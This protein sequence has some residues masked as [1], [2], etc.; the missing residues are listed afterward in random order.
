[1]TK[2]AVKKVIKALIKVRKSTERID[3]MKKDHEELVAS[4]TKEIDAL[5][6]SIEAK[7]QK[8]GELAVWFRSLCRQI[9]SSTRTRILLH[10]RCNK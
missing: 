3:S 5:T 6:A 2:R 1:M 8:I 9:L 4:K 7:T 10:E